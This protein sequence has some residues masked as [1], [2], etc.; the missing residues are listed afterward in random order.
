M[1]DDDSLSS[2]TMLADVLVLLSRDTNS[3]K[4]TKNNYDIST[5]DVDNIIKDGYSM[6]RAEPVIDLL[7]KIIQFLVVEHVHSYNGKE[8]IN[9][10]ESARNLLQYDFNKLVNKGVKLN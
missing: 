7:Q 1:K 3:S 5:D 10:I 9:N 8:P 2:I 6:L 4:L